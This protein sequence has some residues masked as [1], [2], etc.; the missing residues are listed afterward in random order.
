MLNQIQ[1]SEVSESG[2]R[3]SEN[4]LTVILDA[5][6]GS[7]VSGKRS[8]DGLFLEYKF[9]REV[10]DKLIP[11]F[12]L[13]CKNVV[14]VESVEGDLE[15]G[16]QQRCRVANRQSMPAVFISIHANAAGSDGKWHDARGFEIFTSVGETKADKLATEI[17][18]SFA[19]AF[20]E[21]KLRKEYS[22]GD[23]DKEVNFAVLR[24]TKMPAV[25]IE[26]GFQDNRAD[27]AIMSDDNFQDIFAASIVS[28]VITYAKNIL[29]MDLGIEVKEEG[30]DDKE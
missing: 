8:P 16:L 27:V 5:A 3:T 9:S 1:S 21:Y 14:V 24:G 15:P 17:F 25:L 19:A 26:T 23:P 20:P 7:N 18:E 4:Y 10:I 30:P 11:M 28:A 6:H 12:K 29:N 2:F 13:Q 22:D